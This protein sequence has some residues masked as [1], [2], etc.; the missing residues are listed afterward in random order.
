MRTTKLLACTIILLCTFSSCGTA[1]IS[2]VGA[3]SATTYAKESN[4]PLTEAE[5]TALT[6][7]VYPDNFKTLYPHLLQ[8]LQA[9]GC[10]IESSDKA[11]GVIAAK[12]IER[13]KYY[14]RYCLYLSFLLI[15]RP[16]G[17][18]EVRLTIYRDKLER[19]SSVD[20]NIP[21][22]Y[23]VIQYGMASDKTTYDHWF[24]TLLE[25]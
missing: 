15:E 10:Y 12:H 14:S 9:T 24:K 21:T 22:V 1:V 19:G 17:D 13:D 7:R 20:I 16:T 8:R 23:N 25:S 4:T 6:K 11:S 3:T 18:T 2:S 5:I